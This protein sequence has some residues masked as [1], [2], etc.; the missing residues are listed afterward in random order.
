VL[1]SPPRLP[2]RTWSQRAAPTSE[3]R[4]NILVVDDEPG[5]RAYICECLVRESSCHCTGVGSAREALT[6]VHESP[7]PIDVALLDL[8]MPGDDGIALARA[9]RNEV[10]D[11]AVV[12][13]TGTQ[14][15][16]AAVEAMR[17]GILDYLLKPVAMP[18]LVDSVNRAV[19]WRQAALRAAAE[20]A[21][22]RQEI[23]D[24]AKRLTAAF[25]D[26][27]IASRSALEALLEALNQRNPDA[28]AHTR[29]VASF[30]VILAEALDVKEPTL[31]TIERAALL[32]DLGKIA[33]PDAVIHKPGPLTSD[34]L[35]VMRSHVQIGHDIAVTVPFL[36][37][38]GEIILASHERVDGTGY[39]R[40]LKGPAIPL[41]A[42]IIAVADAFDALTSPRL[43][44]EPCDLA[45]ANA[46][47]VRASGTH[48]DPV[49]VASWLR[50]VDRYEA[51]NECEI[52]Q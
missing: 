39:P 27:S 9:L 46:E 15:F 30:S 25:A 31:S 26:S 14:S 44:R 16:D 45:R 23:A 32:H 22:L 21:K 37:P 4:P 49:V 29:R 51:W 50:C 52:L 47:L 8:C 35:S 34:E 5:V 2:G 11:L 10:R 24:N 36:R 20:R 6:V 13:I 18:A 1:Q 17:I 43:Y 19:E 33:I 12:L 42:R 38:V 41:G 28:L 40:G 48:F 7:S 3:P